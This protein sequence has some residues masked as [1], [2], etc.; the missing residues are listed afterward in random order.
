MEL[1]TLANLDP[2]TTRKILL[3]L[4]Y[5]S[6]LKACKADRKIANICDDELNLFWPMKIVRDFGEGLGK[7]RP[8]YETPREQYRSLYNLVDKVV[9]MS[10]NQFMFV[11]VGAFHRANDIPNTTL[12]ITLIK[13]AERLRV[14][15]LV[16]LMAAWIDRLHDQELIEIL[17]NHSTKL[18]GGLYL[19]TYRLP[20]NQRDYEA[21]DGVTRLLFLEYLFCA[22]RLREVKN[23][24][25]EK[26]FFDAAYNY[27]LNN[28][29]VLD[30]D[31]AQLLIER[32]LVSRDTVNESFREQLR[33]FDRYIG[34]HDVYR[35][36]FFSKGRSDEEVLEGMKRAIVFLRDA[37]DPEY[38]KDY[39]EDMFGSDELDRAL[40]FPTS[41][42]E[43]IALLEE[44]YVYHVRDRSLK[45][46][47]AYEIR[48]LLNLI[49][50]SVLSDTTKKVLSENGYIR[51][52][53]GSNSY[54]LVSK[55][56]QALF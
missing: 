39:L 2:D 48:H 55:K 1:A 12:G 38:L 23:A 41:K 43:M 49:D 19:N 10:E 34:A 7:L 5:R 31:L 30:V 52:I 53:K 9:G 29:E 20:G 36:D 45:E 8:K 24:V 25:T 14:D 17:N 21:R 40:N 37:I 47:E 27:S 18:F 3:N 50:P 13:I 6:L 35:R 54:Y 26:D 51:Q 33:N 46:D 4:P 42:A 44:H 11:E 15:A 22:T 32:N 16:V 28:A 56:P